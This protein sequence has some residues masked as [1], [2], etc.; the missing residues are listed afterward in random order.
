MGEIAAVQIDLE[1][2]TVAFADR[3]ATLRSA[4]AQPRA[5]VGAGSATKVKLGAGHPKQAKKDWEVCAID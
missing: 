3:S 2:Q 5:G 4:L 1:E